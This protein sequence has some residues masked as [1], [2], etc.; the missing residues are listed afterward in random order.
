MNTSSSL[1]FRQK[2]ILI[3]TS[4]IIG[5]NEAHILQSIRRYAM[6][7]PEWRLGHLKAWSAEKP[8][9][10]KGIVSWK[11]NGVLFITPPSR[12]SKITELQNIPQV[13]ID[14]RLEKPG[15]VYRV[16]M[17]N[18]V[19]GERAAEYFLQHR[20]KHL[21]VA[22][23]PGNPPFSR[24][25]EK[26]FT[27]AL[28]KVNL[29]PSRFEICRKSDYPW[30][31]NE[32]LE[33]WLRALPKPVGLFCVNELTG[34]RIVEHCEWL[35]IRVP[36]EVSVLVSGND[37]N[38]CETTRPTISS[39]EHPN[40]LIGTRAATI[41]ADCFQSE[42]TWTSIINTCEV[43]QPGE[44]LERQST[45]LSVIQ[46]PAIAK[47]AHFFQEYT[48]QGITIED[49][50]REAG[51]NRRALERGFKHHL[52]VTPGHFMRNVKLDYAKRLLKE[53]EL[54]MCE[55]AESC[56]M[57]PEQFTTF[58]RKETGKTPSAYRKGRTE[59]LAKKG[60]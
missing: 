60:P 59:R 37:P 15:G 31:R 6:A 22:L 29:K 1:K 24:F 2:R 55:I 50:A 8:D 10:I 36:S 58:F 32:E 54:R 51:L 44:I 16:V 20:F 53:T 19:F 46:D 23:W 13:V 47:A 56:N 7:Q 30:F 9:I 40:E 18:E 39:I 35:G 28:Q 25:R 33:A 27:S 4:G 26:G 57:V 34:L 21:A 3:C 11:P 5:F 42:E 52:G 45:T 14:L 41:L 12:F 38:I 17:D 43:I 48:L 49:A